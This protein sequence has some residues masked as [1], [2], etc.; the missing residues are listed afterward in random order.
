MDNF[1]KFYL[2]AYEVSTTIF[3][4]VITMFGQVVTMF[5][6]WAAHSE[7]GVFW[8]VFGWNTHWTVVS[9]MAFAS[10]QLTTLSMCYLKKHQTINNL[11]DTRFFHISPNNSRL[12]IASISLALAIQTFSFS[13]TAKS[14]A[15]QM[16]LVKI[17]YP[18]FWMNFERIPSFVIYEKQFIMFFL[19]VTGSICQVSVGILIFVLTSHMLYILHKN[20][21]KV[22]G[23]MYTKQ[24]IALYGLLAQ[25]STYSCMLIPIACAVVIIALDLQHITNVSLIFILMFSTHSSLNCIV[26]IFTT[27]SFRKWILEKVF[28][29]KTSNNLVN[30]KISMANR[31]T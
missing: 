23:I 15:E 11:T 18:E 21:R 8:R 20:N 25:T 9:I 31:E 1:Y 6:I 10:I 13:M 17:L 27:A 16:K 24:K 4:L 5:P 29:R 22:S 3:D 30:V 28:C 12:L 14:K 2:L 7:H 19:L 26:M